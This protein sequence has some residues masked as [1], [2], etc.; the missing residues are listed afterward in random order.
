[1]SSIYE[2][3]PFDNI[4]R[5][6]REDLS[7]YGQNNPAPISKTVITIE[8]GFKMFRHYEL[9]DIIGYVLF[10]Y[11]DDKVTHVSPMIS[12][13]HED[14][15]Y[16]FA[17]RSPLYMA[18]S[19]MNNQVKTL[20]RMHKWYHEHISEGFDNGKWFSNVIKEITEEEVFNKNGSSAC[21]VLSIPENN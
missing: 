1:M 21:D 10:G 8:D 12:E 18:A 15:E 5:F 9:G 2:N 7:E 6:V 16:W 3:V 14:D 11:I 17:P 13:I 4:Q 19:W 20:Q